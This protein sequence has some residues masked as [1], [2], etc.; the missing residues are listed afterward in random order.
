MALDGADGNLGSV[1][2]DMEGHDLF[3]VL[4]GLVE[5]LAILVGHPGT[6]AMSEEHGPFG[7]AGHLEDSTCL[8]CLAQKAQGES[9]RWDLDQRGLL[10]QIDLLHRLLIL[11]FKLSIESDVLVDRQ[12]FTASVPRD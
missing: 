12:R 8:P 10:L 7:H 6:R 11:F 2:E 9:L 4:D 5:L 1:G 3:L